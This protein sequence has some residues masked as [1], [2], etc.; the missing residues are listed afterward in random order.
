MSSNQII[1]E[2][3][4]S[5]LWH[6]CTQMKDHEWL[7]MIPIKRGEGVW[8][9]DFD[10][11]RYIDAVS[12]WWV[13]LFG[14]ANP[15]INAALKSQVDCLEHVM[16]AGF[17]HEPAIQLAEQL[18]EIT[19]AGL[20][21]CFYV[22]NGSSAVE[23]ALKM[24]YHSWRNQGHKGKHHF[25]T[26]SN[27]YHGETLGALAVGDVSL[28]K[29]TY[30]PL[31]MEVFTA[32][33]PDCYERESGESWEDYSTRQ[34]AE[35]E[36]L[37]ATHGDEISAVIVEPLVQC[38]GGMRMY[39]PVYLTLL[40]K[41]CDRYQIH[42]IADEIAVGFGRTGSM[43][44]CE[45]ASIT[46][47][48]LCLSKGLTAGYLPLSVVMTSEQTYR[49]FYD[50]YENLTAFL[51]SHSYTGNPLGCAVALASLNIFR[52]DN[53][54][55]NNRNL[56]QVMSEATAHLVDHPHVAEVRQHG[57]ILAI[58]MVKEKKNRVPYDWQERRGLRVYQHA[59]KQGALLRPLG[60][61]TYFMPPYVIT[62]D[63]I[64][65]LARIAT[66]GIDLATR[67]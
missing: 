40:R 24:S 14:H 9:E 16:L 50:D 56:A 58:E 27:S 63:Q 57:M 10:G 25:V 18:V 22:D 6:P 17:S 35:M 59:L 45:Q 53:I 7:P 28:Y 15:R 8:L 34:F 67:N 44:A 46:P 21:R 47:D 52:D 5:V 41:S 49:N 60:N 23:A 43:F 62:P 37:L 38:A 42:L 32:P 64:K 61:V 19:P 48:F 20:D 36:Q 1:S 4:L 2:R 12:S 33:S 39:H 65:T 13:N 29:E 11:K 26:L 55:E 51:H 3:D 66:E 54:I 30:E 31:L